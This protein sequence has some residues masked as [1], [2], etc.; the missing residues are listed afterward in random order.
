MHDDTCDALTLTCRLYMHRPTGVRKSTVLFTELTRRKRE[1]ASD[2]ARLRSLEEEVRHVNGSRCD[3]A[4]AARPP[5]AP[6]LAVFGGGATARRRGLV[7]GGRGGMEAGRGGR[8]GQAGQGEGAVRAGPAGEG[9]RVGGRA[10]AR[11]AR[12]AVA[13]GRR[14]RVPRRAHAHRLHHHGAQDA[15]RAAVPRL[16]HHSLR[17]AGYVVCTLIYFLCVRV[18]HTRT[19]RTDR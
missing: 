10:G 8:A 15:V 4:A 5:A 17:A 12:P 14:L 3:G 18:R 6:P 7:G 9:G 19:R 13:A 2:R 1:R 11:G 16:Q